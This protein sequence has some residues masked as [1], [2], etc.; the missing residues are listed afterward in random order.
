MKRFLRDGYKTAKEDP[1]RLHYEPWE[2]RS[3]VFIFHFFVLC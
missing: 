1:T 3:D 2:L